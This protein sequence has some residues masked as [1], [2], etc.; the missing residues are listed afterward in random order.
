MRRVT[1]SLLPALLLAAATVASLPVE[2]TGEAKPGA[3]APGTTPVSKQQ[4]CLDMK[5]RLDAYQASPKGAK[6]PETIKKD[7]A[8]Y[9]Q[10]C[11]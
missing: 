2:A 8:W 9:Q 6:S 5:K 7:I 4:A 1:R 10:N 3:K 11:K